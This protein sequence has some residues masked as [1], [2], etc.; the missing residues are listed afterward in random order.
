MSDENM[1]AVEAFT[2]G[3]RTGVA[4]LR[5]GLDASVLPLVLKAEAADLVA[6]AQADS[7]PDQLADKL[8]HLSP[9]KAQP[10]RRSGE[11]GNPPTDTG[12]NSIY[13]RM[14]AEQKKAEEPLNK[15][16]SAAERL[17]KGGHW[18]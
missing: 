10:E 1:T 15:G 6:E 4:A 7:S 12:D 3:V 16:S 18:S 11:Q 17:D 9:L 2:L 14:R 5:K 8:V 13:D